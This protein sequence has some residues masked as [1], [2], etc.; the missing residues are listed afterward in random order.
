MADYC[1]RLLAHALS[2]E[3]EL[4]GKVLFVARAGIRIRRAVEVFAAAA[5]VDL[6][7]RRDYLWVSRLM[8]AKG[9]WRRNRS[10]ALQLLTKEFAHAS[11]KD[12]V[13]AMFR[14]DGVP[15]SVD[16]DDP[17]L[18]QRASDLAGFL[19][20]HSPAARAVE[21][22]FCHQ[23]KLFESYIAAI[24]ADHDLALLV[25]TGWQGTAQSLLDEAFP[26]VTWWGAYFGRF[27]TGGADQR[28]WPRVIGVVTE[29]DRFDPAWPESSVIL[30]RHL[31]E[32]LFQ[33]TGPS[34]E[35]LDVGADGISSP[36]AQE[37]LRDNVSA[38]ASPMFAGVLDYLAELPNGTGI[39]ALRRASQAA[40]R[41][42]ARVVT[43]PTSEDVAL[44]SDV[45]RSADFG[46]SIEVPL[47]LPARN[48]HR[49]DSPDARVRDSLWRAGQLTIEYPREI[50]Q[51][52][53]R[54]LAGIRNS[55][56]SDA[57]GALAALLPAAT[58]V[59]RPKVAIITRTL[60]RPTFLKRALASVAAQTFKDYVHVI[61][62]DGGDIDVARETIEAS[63]GDLDRTILVDNVINRGMEAASNIA[64]RHCGS[65]YVVIHDDDDTWEPVFLEKTLGFLESPGGRLYDGVIT[66]ST[67]VSESVTA[68][69]IVIHGSGPY[70]GWVQTV[71]L[72]EMAVQ[73]FFPPIAFVFRRSRYDAIGGYDERYP[74]LGDW[75][76]N[77]RFLS[78]ANIAVLP[79]ALA[80][81]HHRDRGDTAVF[82]NSV[83]AD[84]HKHLEYSAVVRNNLV[85]DL[86][87]KGRTAEASM[88]GLGVLL[89]EDR[90]LGR[91]TNQKLDALLGSAAA[92]GD[93]AV[94]DRP[95]GVEFRD[96][97]WVAGQ[98]LAQ[99]VARGDVAALSELGLA[100]NPR[101]LRQRGMR[102]LAR[103]LGLTRPVFASNRFDLSGVQSKQLIEQLVGLHRDPYRT[104]PSPEDFDDLRYLRE[105]PD[106]ASAVSRGELTSGFEHYFYTGQREGRSR[107]SC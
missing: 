92:V 21:D 74:V 36:E 100:A 77:L 97:L 62:N 11:L 54:K 17:A 4:D 45:L 53:Q 65:D 40:W 19:A 69:G 99:I 2:F 5:G 104:L 46:R 41:E 87:T 14:Y 88:I 85:R 72:H 103:L 101:D 59:H 70:H 105:N 42:V 43:Q 73:N 29:H 15:S 61:I 95:G 79:E 39:G 90:D 76:F 81:Y 82:G 106:V 12:F 20:S 23:S 18:K 28:V 10:S 64:I 6:P 35:R 55:P 9:V 26:N 1:A 75:D 93:R 13:A 63:S 7:S 37:V 34:I 31:I 47:L 27:P 30:H 49:D 78:E 58:T 96:A 57:L 60:D 51:P 56:S 16:L 84:R 94:G 48:R 89:G 33:P 83:I 102:V 50:A 32:H 25:D 80:N 71:H 98:R 3:R 8:V 86:T 22:H 24:V 67:Y 44:F 38:E 66:H 52:M 68:S 107:P 91:R